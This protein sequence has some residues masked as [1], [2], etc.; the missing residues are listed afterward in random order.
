MDVQVS[1]DLDRDGIPELPV[2][3]S[4]LITRPLCSR[5]KWGVMSGLQGGASCRNCS[6][7]RC[8]S[9][10]C[11]SAASIHT[12]SASRSPAFGEDSGTS[13]AD[14]TN[15][16]SVCRC[17]ES[18]L[19]AVGFDTDNRRAAY[20]RLEGHPRVRDHLDG[21]KRSDWLAHREVWIAARVFYGDAYDLPEGL[22]RFDV[23]I[24][25]QILVHMQDVVRALTSISRQSADAVILAEGM[26]V[27]DE[28]TSLF[29]GSAQEPDH[30]RAF[31]RHSV[32]LYRELLGMLGFSLEAPRTGK[33]T[34]NVDG[35]PKATPITTLVFKRRLIST[36]VASRAP[37]RV[38]ALRRLLRDPLNR[39]EGRCAGSAWSGESRT[40]LPWSFAGAAASWAPASWRAFATPRYVLLREPDDGRPSHEGSWRRGVEKVV[41]VGTG[42]WR[43]A[44]GFFHGMTTGCFSCGTTSRRRHSSAPA[45]LGEGRSDLR[46]ERNL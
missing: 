28:P 16:R 46:R 22:G 41:A 18:V 38:V 7:N 8:Q 1:R 6:Q 24:V 4:E 20:L 36:P 9:R 25:G 11:R 2:A 40:R 10:G 15:T 17:G 23:V 27:T 37:D 43:S 5:G 19:D 13:A 34:C 35:N 12:R 42:G 33:F 39:L 31:W 32:G 3:S 29:L 26:L 30:D 45:D 21:L 44:A 14:S